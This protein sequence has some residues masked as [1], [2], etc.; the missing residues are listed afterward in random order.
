M[1][2]SLKL[3]GKY[4]ELKNIKIK[5]HLNMM[6]HALDK[7]EK[8]AVSLRKTKKNE[9]LQYKRAKLLAEMSK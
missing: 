1:L 6:N 3:C 7:R 8:F 5:T 9:F 4:K 2:E